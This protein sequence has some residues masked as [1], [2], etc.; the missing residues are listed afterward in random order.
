MAVDDLLTQKGWDGIRQVLAQLK[1]TGDFDSAMVQV[2]GLDEQSFEWE[3][4]KSLRRQYRWAVLVDPMFYVGFGFI[5][6]LGLAGYMV[7]RRKRKILKEW[8]EH[9]PDIY[10]GEINP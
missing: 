5:P 2:Y 4:L 10:S 3:F 8:E 6:L 9:P 1:A 7:W